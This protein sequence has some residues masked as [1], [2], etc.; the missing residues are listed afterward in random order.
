[1][2]LGALPWQEAFRTA[3]I[4]GSNISIAFI[5]QITVFERRRSPVLLLTVLLVR[6]MLVN[7]LGGI[8][9][10]D[11]IIGN[12]LFKSI[13]E[14]LITIQPLILWGL[15]FYTFKGE[16]LKL[17][18]VSMGAEIYTVFLNCVVLMLVNYGEGRENLLL[19]AGAFQWTDLWIPILM[20]GAFLPAYFIFR[21]KLLAIREKKLKH[22]KGCLIFSSLYFL[23]GLVSWWN[24]YAN[25]MKH[26]SW[27]VWMI[28]FVLAAGAGAACI[29]QWKL[30]MKTMEAE[31]RP[32]KRQQ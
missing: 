22:R 28:F 13:Y 7:L 30:Y 25:R 23:T 14:L 16:W 3:L 4:L 17:V 9:F 24:G 18:T 27:F 26:M 11:Y 20:Y 12:P 6:G 29:T 19:S 15:V 2:E 5:I 8:V 1:M 10:Q 32:L 21:E 31:Y